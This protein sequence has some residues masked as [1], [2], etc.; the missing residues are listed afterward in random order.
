[1]NREG[2][3]AV[4]PGVTVTAPDVKRIPNMIAATPHPISGHDAAGVAP[5]VI[6]DAT[7]EAVL[8]NVNLEVLQRYLCS[9]ET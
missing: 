6:L 2:A 7:Q 3:L 8:Q 9:S 4:N 5:P 1:M